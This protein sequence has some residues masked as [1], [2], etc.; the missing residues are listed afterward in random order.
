MSFSI[1]DISQI[2]FGY[3]QRLLWVVLDNHVEPLMKSEEAMMS[4]LV[5][6]SVF[7][8]CKTAPNQFY[9]DSNFYNRSRI[10]HRRHDRTG[11]GV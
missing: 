6:S 10:I 7:K 2:D 8:Y 9:W 11:M 4:I 3:G 5:I 1:T